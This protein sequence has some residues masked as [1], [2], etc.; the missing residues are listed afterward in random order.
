MANLNL[1]SILFNAAGAGVVLIVA[2][3]MVKS[4]FV[5][6]VTPQCSQRYTN[7]QQFPLQSA[8]GALLSPLE[9]QARVST[10]EWGLLNNARVVEASDKSAM[11]L[12]VAMTAADND[13]EADSA[14]SATTNGVGFTWQPQSLSGTRAACLSYRVFLPKNFSF[15]GPGTL[16]GLFAT[17][18]VAELDEAQPTSGF[19]SRLGWK[20]DGAL[21]MEFRTPISA[22]HWLAAKGMRWPTDRWVMIE[23]EVVLNS[24]DKANGQVRLWVDGELKVETTAMNLGSAEHTTLS[25]VV[26][27]IGYNRDRS[28]SGRLTLSPFLIQKQ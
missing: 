10:R 22:G 3:Y 20:K 25:G 7:G 14:G 13:E 5:T 11:Y 24:K 8:K 26:A 18:S 12:Q 23:Q 15:A 6:E 19:V 21:G 2:G 4:F 27:D 17:S 9:L 1:K 16:P 28:Q